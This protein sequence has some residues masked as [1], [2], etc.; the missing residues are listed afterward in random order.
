MISRNHNINSLIDVRAA[1]FIRQAFY[2]MGKLALR[3]E[4]AATLPP[5]YHFK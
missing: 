4:T 2:S 5:P 1:D 3:L